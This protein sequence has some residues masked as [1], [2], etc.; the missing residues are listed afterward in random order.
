MIKLSSINSCSTTSKYWNNHPVRVELR[1]SH[2]LNLAILDTTGPRVL[3]RSLVVVNSYLNDVLAPVQVP[4]SHLINHVPLAVALD[5]L[6]V[7]LILRTI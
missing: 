6:L 2:P 1:T 5:V 3:K 4:R 7:A